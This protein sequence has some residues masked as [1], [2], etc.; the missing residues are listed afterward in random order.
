MSNMKN[1][2]KFSLH[3][4]TSL[5]NTKLLNIVLSGITS[6]ALAQGRESDGF[7]EKPKSRHSKRR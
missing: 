6:S 3:M 4:L 5:K 1:N 7:N 2:M